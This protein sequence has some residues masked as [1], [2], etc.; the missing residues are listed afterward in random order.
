MYCLHC[1]LEYCSVFFESL[2]NFEP[3]QSQLYCNK[4]GSVILNI[5]GFKDATHS[6]LIA[7]IQSEISIMV[8][9]I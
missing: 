6:R 2:N 9:V 3:N 1:I 8:T 4:R 5:Q 7:A